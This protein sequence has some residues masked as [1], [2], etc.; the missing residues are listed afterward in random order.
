MRLGAVVVL[1]ALSSGCYVKRSEVLL[2]VLM[3]LGGP[4]AGAVFSDE[5][6]GSGYGE[7]G[8]V[9][10]LD[11]D[12]LVGGWALATRGV[13]I[14]EGRTGVALYGR[15]E[16]GSNNDDFYGI[17]ATQ[18]GA[19]YRL[20]RSMTVAGLFGYTYGGIPQN[21][22]TF[23]FRLVGLVD[24]SQAVGLQT[25]LYAGWR[26]WVGN[27][28]PESESSFGPGWNTY[29]GDVALR[30][31]PGTGVAIGM[32]FDRQDDIS[33]IGLRLSLNMYAGL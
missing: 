25:S 29:G 11:E 23:P 22:H 12:P 3:S 30:I 28:Y 31:G 18:V 24:W 26:E 32:S 2:P 5:E 17:A 13:A 10:T 6:G 7:I 8:V 21:G 9:H 4:S 20:N 16:A 14:L 33:I 27:H 1:C 19:A 15:F